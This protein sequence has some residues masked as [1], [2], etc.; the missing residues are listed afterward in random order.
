MF[1]TYYKQ[2][3]KAFNLIKKDNNLELHR[4]CA[5]TREHKLKAINYYFNYL[6]KAL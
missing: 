6:G 1:Q 2:Y 4:C 3:Q 5:Y